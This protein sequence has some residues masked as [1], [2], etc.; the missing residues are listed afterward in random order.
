MPG[1]I[2][3]FFTRIDRSRIPAYLNYPIY[4]QLKNIPRNP[5]IRVLKSFF[6][7]IFRKGYEVFTNERIVEIPFVYKY[8][9]LPIRARILDFGCSE[10][11]VSIE[12]ASLGYDVTGVDLNDYAL[13]HPNFRFVKGNFLN[14]TFSEESFDAVVAISAVEH[15]GLPDAYGSEE[16]S[17][18]DRKIVE[19][20]HR[21]L[22]KGGRLIMT[23][24]Y[25]ERALVLGAYGQRIY[26]ADSLCSLLK[27]F[28]IVKEQYFMGMDRKQWL[29]VAKE[30]L[31]RVDSV[32]KGF[33]QGVAC[34]VGEKY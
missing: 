9:N 24:P 27:R 11:M 17:N 25:G 30:E 3:K 20:F 10:S 5:I 19:E 16:F 4:L 26:D 18:G 8:L 13:T 1:I 15:C 22:K 7:S 34:I 6:L 14:N 31:A 28:K 29:P 21:V 12:L 2:N 33:V 23:V 32:S